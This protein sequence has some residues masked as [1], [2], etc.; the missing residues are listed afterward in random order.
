MTTTAKVVEDVAEAEELYLAWDELAK[1]GGLPFCAPA[2]MLAW[3]RNARPERAR[4]RLIS[5]HDGDEVI[6]IAPLFSIKKRSGTD[7]AHFLGWQTSV[8]A[9]PMAVAGREAEV[10]QAV[11]DA[12]RSLKPRIELLMF[13]G[14]P[15][16]S[17]WP[18]LLCEAWPGKEP[19]KH[20][21]YP[22]LAPTLDL[23]GRDYEAW[24]A[25]RSSH[26]RQE[27]RRRRRHLEE[28]GAEF[29][30][31]ESAEDV[32]DALDAFFRLHHSRWQ[33][34][35]GSRVL[36]EEVQAMLLDAALA[37]VPETR[38]RIWTIR[39]KGEVISAHIFV[40]AGG[41]VAYWLGGFDDAWAKLGPAIQS[42]LK[43]LE[44]AWARGDKRMDF[45][46]GAQ[47]YKYSFAESQDVLESVV[48]AP[49]SPSYPLTRLQLLP[50]LAREAVSTRMSPELRDKLNR[51]RKRS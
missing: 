13:E 47:E 38:F 5:V 28:Q 34:R 7:E 51:L 22:T 49:R 32:V 21:S 36:N 11:I 35:G 17:R 24:F 12:L 37:L 27:A 20:R 18:I 46:A 3:W 8:R 43:A 42:V 48:I 2:W 6:G 9:E 10:A 26:F 45:G 41:E 23:T 44:D 29:I 33:G 14:V 19:Y 15:T 39:V 31:A 4:L 1:A 25:S 40:A 30:L 16:R 50:R